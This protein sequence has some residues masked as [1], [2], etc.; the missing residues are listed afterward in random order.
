MI[1]FNNHTTL[2]KMIEA[3]YGRRKNTV[4]EQSYWVMLN[5]F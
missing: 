3:P 2:K 4:T 5:I 1:H